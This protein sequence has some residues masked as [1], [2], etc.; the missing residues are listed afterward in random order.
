MKRIRGPPRESPEESSQGYPGAGGGGKAM[1][2][3]DVRPQRESRTTLNHSRRKVMRKAQT[4]AK[5]ITEWELLNINIKPHLQ[6]MPY[7]QEI[8]TALDALIAEAKGLDS[9]QE[10]ARG[11]SS[12]TSST[13]ARRWR[14]RGDPAPPGGVPS[15][16]ELRVHQRRAGEVRGAAPARRAR[17][18]RE[19]KLRRSRP[20]SPRR[21]PLRNPSRGPRRG[22]PLAFSA[23]FWAP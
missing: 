12:R 6:D 15:Q 8:V 11:A 17:G 22:G 23:G 9:Q 5:K 13:S 7:L 16:G 18:V 2:D 10:A 19:S 14:S 4:F 20:G 3:R 1:P 21:I